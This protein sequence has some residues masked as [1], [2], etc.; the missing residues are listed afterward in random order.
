MG[1]KKINIDLAAVE[2]LAAVGMTQQEIAAHLGIHRATLHARRKESAAVDRAF[3]KGRIKAKVVAVSALWQAIQRGE[4][5]AIKYYLTTRCGWKPISNPE[6]TGAGGSDLIPPHYEV[7]FV[8]GPGRG[9][10]ANSGGE[11][12]EAK[13]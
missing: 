6:L 12:D 10:Y 8:D 5:S 7:Q 1:R 11:D 13:S 3:E 9:T 2:R 4:V